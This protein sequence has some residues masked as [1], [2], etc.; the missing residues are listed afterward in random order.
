MW[1]DRILEFEE[2]QNNIK[3]KIIKTRQEIKNLKNNRVR[4][5]ICKID[6]HRFSCS[7]QIK[8]KKRLENIRQNKVLLPWKNP[9]RRVVKEDMQVSDTKV[10][11]QY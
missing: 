5:D 11:N 8:S 2:L 6:L 4:C 10:E 1:E 9:I 3:L 7:R